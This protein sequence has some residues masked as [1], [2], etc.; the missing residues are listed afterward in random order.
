MGDHHH[1]DLRVDARQHHEMLFFGEK[2][3]SMSLVPD[4]VGSNNYRDSVL[5]E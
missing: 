5:E 4:A 1:S 2:M 3:D